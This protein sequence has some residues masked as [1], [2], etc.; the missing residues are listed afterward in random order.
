MYLNINVSN[1]TQKLPH[2]PLVGGL[3]KFVNICKYTSTT[4][5]EYHVPWFIREGTI[6]K[7]ER[8][9]DLGGKRGGI[10][11]ERIMKHE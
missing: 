6:E 7:N 3:L 10:L 9:D 1:E 8:E 2:L 11:R 5:H 4:R